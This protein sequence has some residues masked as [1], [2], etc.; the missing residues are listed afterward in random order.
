LAVYRT[1]NISS[2][3][4]IITYYSTGDEFPGFFVMKQRENGERER[5]QNFHNVIL[6]VS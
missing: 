3:I 2:H 5:E 4:L 1:Y 6:D